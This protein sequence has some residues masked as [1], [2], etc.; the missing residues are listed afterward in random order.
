MLVTLES[1]IV[2]IGT[3]NRAM[4]TVPQ[5]ILVVKP[6]MIHGFGVF[7]VKDLNKGIRLGPYDGQITRVESTKGYSWKLKDGRLVSMTFPLLHRYFG[8]RQSVIWIF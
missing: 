4:R 6:S 8:T 7:A 1:T 3:A 2:P 5:G